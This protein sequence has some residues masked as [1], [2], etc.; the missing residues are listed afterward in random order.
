[1]NIRGCDYLVIKMMIT[2][3][4]YSTIRP[5]REVFS[6]QI[7]CYILKNIKELNHLIRYLV[8]ELVLVSV[9]ELLS[10][11]SP[12]MFVLYFVIVFLVIKNKKCF[13][14]PCMHNFQILVICYVFWSITV[15]GSNEFIFSSVAD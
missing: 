11:W 13:F 15:Q 12:Y 1:M 2:H 3:S 8:L 10:R 14:T 6:T 5:E 9:S 7:L 4:Y